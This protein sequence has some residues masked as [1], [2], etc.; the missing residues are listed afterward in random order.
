MKTSIYVI[1][2]TI[3][4]SSIFIYNSN[5]PS[6]EKQIQ[7]HQVQALP[8]KIIAGEVHYSRI[9]VEYWEHRLQTIK[10]MGFNALSVYIMWNYHQIEKG[11]FDYQ[12]ENKNLP[13]FLTLAQKYGF[14]V[15]IRP[16][17][18][19]CAEWDFGGFP[20]RLL[21]VDGIKLRA[22]NAVYLNEVKVY[23]ESLVPILKPFWAKNGGSIILLQ[24]ENEYGFYGNDK[25]YME[26]LRTMWSSLDID[27][28]QYYV[29][30][31]YNLEKCYW[32]GANIGINDGNTEVQYEFA[33]TLGKT[34]VIFGG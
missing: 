9:P 19:V 26:A 29:D 2:T 4:L 27:S 25:S 11:K 13:L 32:S 24:I 12:T 15:L 34:G 14:Y 30:T 16:G 33:K 8:P 3:I 20:A 21:N 22:N 28:E 31:V 7:K 6:Q 10:A 17:P 1:V 18:Y 23:F 5:Y